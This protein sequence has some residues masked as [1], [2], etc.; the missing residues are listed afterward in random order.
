MTPAIASFDYGPLPATQADELRVKA[1]TIRSRTGTMTPSI[2]DIG[3]DLLVAK[4]TLPHGCLLPWVRAECGLAPRTAQNYMRVAEFADGKCESGSLLTPSAIYAL[5]SKKAPPEVVHQ[6]LQQL[7]S[8]QEIS[9]GLHL[10]LV[11]HDHY[12]ETQQSLQTRQR[13]CHE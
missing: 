8:N 2:I 10:R 12:Q 3:R 13:L 5:S 9:D 4:Q 1:S 6:V 11:D 7:E